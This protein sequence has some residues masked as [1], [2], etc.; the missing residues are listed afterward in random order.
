VEECQLIFLLGE[1]LRKESKKLAAGSSFP[2]QTFKFAL[3]YDELLTKS[4]TVE[5]VSPKPS[6]FGVQKHGR[7]I[8]PLSSLN[9]SDEILLWLELESVNEKS[10]GELQLYFSYLSSAERLILTVQES[11][12]LQ[13]LDINQSELTFI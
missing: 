1:G 11:I 4:L 2:L 10:C 9:P 13:R 8:M 5:L 7:S 12:N 3:S 6:G